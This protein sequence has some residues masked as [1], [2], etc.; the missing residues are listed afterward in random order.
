MSGLD[1]GP[2]SGQHRRAAGAEREVERIIN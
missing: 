1:Q 2:Q